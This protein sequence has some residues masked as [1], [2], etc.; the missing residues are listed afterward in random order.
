MAYI[1]EDGLRS[2]SSRRE[3]ESHDS[4][5]S[6]SELRNLVV[7]RIVR[8]LYLYARSWSRLPPAHHCT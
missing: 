4:D 7:E 3:C 8:L 5:Q 2:W 1:H 6:M